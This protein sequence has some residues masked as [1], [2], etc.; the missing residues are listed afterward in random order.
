M[1]MATER[2]SPFRLICR[3]LWRPAG[4]PEMKLSTKLKLYRTL[5]RV[6][7]PR[8]VVFSGKYAQPR[9]LLF[10]FPVDKDLFF[11]S[12]HV[13]RAL[14]R[15][16]VRNKVHLAI[17]HKFREQIPAPSQRTFYY[18]LLNN[19]PPQI[20]GQALRRHY[21]GKAY[22][23]IINLSP[24]IDLPLAEV[25]CAIDSPKRIGMA[26]PGADELYNIQIRPSNGDT[27]ESVYD[28]MLALCDLGSLG[29]HP[30]YDLWG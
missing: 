19:E 17:A 20:D 24:E 7:A 11:V 30:D 12:L 21:G 22:D 28:Q 1:N 25:I 14:E 10:L 29:K 15:H 5:G 27:L 3:K 16:S 8:D 23:A 26:G 2:V 6:S 18:P 9:T 13:I 4:S